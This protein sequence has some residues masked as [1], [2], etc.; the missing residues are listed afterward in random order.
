MAKVLVIQVDNV[1]NP[2]KMV[3]KEGVGP[4][5]ATSCGMMS[6]SSRLQTRNGSRN[7]EHQ[8][9]ISRGSTQG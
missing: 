2:L 5:P 6:L 4:L 1:T 9:I 7:G 3:L 8:Q